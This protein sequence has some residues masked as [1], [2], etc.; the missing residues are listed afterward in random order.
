MKALISGSE[1]SHVKTTVNEVKAKLLAQ[2]L[3]S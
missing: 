3:F 2:K 1:N